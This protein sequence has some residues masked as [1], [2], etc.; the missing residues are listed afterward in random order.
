[1]SPFAN[2]SFPPRTKVEP[3]QLPNLMTFFAPLLDPMPDHPQLPPTEL[4]A[5]VTNAATIEEDLN[6]EPD[7]AVI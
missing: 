7:N 4:V 3:A 2:Y 1:M 5:D 6:G